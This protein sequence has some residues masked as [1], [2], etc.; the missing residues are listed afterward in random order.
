LYNQYIRSVPHFGKE[1]KE[2]SKDQFLIDHPH[3]LP[4]FLKKQISKRR[5]PWAITIIFFKQVFS[6]RESAVYFVRHILPP[7]MQ[8]GIDYTTLTFEKDSHKES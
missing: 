4:Y 5:K 1:K 8:E 6:I 7:S 2:L 3:F